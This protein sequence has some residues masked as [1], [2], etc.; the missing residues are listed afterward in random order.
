M[1]CK[2]LYI[3]DARRDE[4]RIVNTCEIPSYQM[5]DHRIQSYL[6][7][8]HCSWLLY[9][10]LAQLHLFVSMHFKDIE[11]AARELTDETILIYFC[12]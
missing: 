1:K 10:T 3:I 6:G 5:T 2:S 11:L 9:F 12:N 7:F 8:Q 4:T